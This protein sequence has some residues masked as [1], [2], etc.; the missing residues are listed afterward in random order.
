[1]KAKAHVKFFISVDENG[2]IRHEERE[3]RGPF[4]E[5]DMEF[6]S[7]QIRNALYVGFAILAKSILRKQHP[8]KLT[9]DI[10]RMSTDVSNIEITFQE[11]DK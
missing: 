1:M 11:E 10:R 8:E 4:L 3:R 7:E 2:Y 9:G 5:L 6:D